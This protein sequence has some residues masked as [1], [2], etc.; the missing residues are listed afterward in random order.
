MYRAYV[1]N[2]QCQCMMITIQCMLPKIMILICPSLGQL[3]LRKDSPTLS[4]TARHDTTANAEI[5]SLRIP[6]GRRQVGA[7]LPMIGWIQGEHLPCLKYHIPPVRKCSLV[8]PRERASEKRVKLDS[9]LVTLELWES[10][11]RSAAAS[12][13]GTGRQE[14]LPSR[15][16]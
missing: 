15:L 9:N 7:R 4:R 10:K 5:H 12:A 1:P 11:G 6:I 14:Y 13:G 3:K 16:C 8:S 2:C